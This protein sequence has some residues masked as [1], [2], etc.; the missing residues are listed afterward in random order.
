VRL[1]LL[2]V[3]TSSVNDIPSSGLRG[4]ILKSVRRRWTPCTTAPLCSK[5]Q[6]LTER[7][8]P[9]H[10]LQL[11]S[12]GLLGHCIGNSLVHVW[13]CVLEPEVDKPRVV[14]VAVTDRVRPEAHALKQ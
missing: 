5:A 8:T 13:E 2:N 9:T 3:L 1:T 4:C 7:H 6:T 11:R 14:L 12:R 10:L